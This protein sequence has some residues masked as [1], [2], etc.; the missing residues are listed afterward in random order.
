MTTLLIC[1]TATRFSWALALL[2]TTTAVAHAEPRS[3]A[4]EEP[5]A[6]APLGA[7]SAV[8][9]ERAGPPWG[10]GYEQRQA[11]RPGTSPSWPV[12]Q[13]GSPPWGRGAMGG[14]LGGD[15]GGAGRGRGR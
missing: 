7:A 2:L 3:V 11:Q 10:A 6:S 1:P 4:P 14:G 8:R 15:R 12:P 9:M 13:G 5:A